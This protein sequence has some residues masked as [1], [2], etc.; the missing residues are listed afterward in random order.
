MVLVG[1]DGI[2]PL[3]AAHRRVAVIGPIA[4]STRDLLGDYTTL[5]THISQ[6]APD[7]TSTEI[8]IGYMRFRTFE[9]LA[10]ISNF[11]AFLTS[12]RVTGTSDPEHMKQDLASRAL[13]LSAESVQAIESLAG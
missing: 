5:Y 1:N 3:A 6:L 8:G 13:A 9:D 11:A 4:D 2:L 7:G 10:A 12:F